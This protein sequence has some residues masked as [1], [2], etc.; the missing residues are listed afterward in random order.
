VQRSATAVDFREPGGSRYLRVDQTNTPNN[1][2]VGDWTR[3]EASVRKRLGG[4]QRIRI[5]P[6]RYRDYIAADWEFTYGNTRVL[7][8]GMNT[9]AKGYALYWSTPKSQWNESRPMFDVF[10][11]TFRPAG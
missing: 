7:N 10:A 6:V 3:Q 1:D 2:P 5:D 8:R 9:G 11:Q 4:Y